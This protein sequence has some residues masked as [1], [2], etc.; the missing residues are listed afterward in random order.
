MDPLSITA[1]VLAIVAHT[2]NALQ[3]CQNY[4]TTYKIADLSIASIRTEC[5]SIRVALLQI[6]SLISRNPD[7]DVS[8]RFD[9]DVLEEYEAVL[10]A[11]SLTFAILKERFAGLGLDGLNKR[12]E[13]DFGTKLRYMWNE[14]QM[15]MIRQNIRGQ[16]IAINLLLTAFQA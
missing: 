11:C 8:D 14:P 16:A 2:I 7:R 1:G 4:V 12:N 13:S 10:G 5:S 15:D 9:R 6:R 3:S